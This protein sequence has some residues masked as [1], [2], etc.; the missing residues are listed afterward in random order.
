M[1]VLFINKFSLELHLSNYF[2]KSASIYAQFL[3][4]DAA[5]DT[6]K[7]YNPFKK[8]SLV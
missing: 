7:E 8:D 3:E 5:F 4:M 1:E 6:F 2:K